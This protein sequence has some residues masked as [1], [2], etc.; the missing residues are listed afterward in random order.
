[1]RSALLL[2]LVISSQVF[3]GFSPKVVR[4]SEPVAVRKVASPQIDFCPTCVSFMDQALDQL[5]NILLSEH[6]KTMTTNVKTLESLEAALNSVVCYPTN[7][8]Q[9][10]VIYFATTLELKSSLMPSMRKCF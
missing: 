2:I 10:L 5:L 8:W 9:P 4:L 7:S 6:H 3:A 1:M